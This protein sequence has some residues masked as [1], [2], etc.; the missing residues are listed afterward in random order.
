MLH[1]SSWDEC[2][3]FTMIDLQIGLSIW[4]LHRYLSSL[5]A[6]LDVLHESAF[7]M[8][9]ISLCSS[10]NFP[11]QP[12]VYMPNASIES[13]FLSL[14]QLSLKPWTLSL[15]PYWV[16]L[17]CSI[18]LFVSMYIQQLTFDVVE[19]EIN[20]VTWQL[21]TLTWIFR[22][23]LYICKFTLRKHIT[24][25]THLYS[26]QRKITITGLSNVNIQKYW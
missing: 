12:G 23:P 26:N 1:E 6:T 15:E 8:P 16:L 10:V 21:T 19:R 3:T 11:C 4:R 20:Y 14:S 7:I 9:I 2:L 18:P 13:D 24:F 5:D 25:L 22:L 17:Y